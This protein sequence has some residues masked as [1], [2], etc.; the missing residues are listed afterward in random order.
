MFNPKPVGCEPVGWSNGIGFSIG[1]IVNV[2]PHHY[3]AHK[4]IVS[5]D[6]VFMYLGGLRCCCNTDSLFG[7]FILVVA[8]GSSQDNA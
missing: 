4:N 1:Y 3:L 8:V 7:D 2:D 5:F 6:I